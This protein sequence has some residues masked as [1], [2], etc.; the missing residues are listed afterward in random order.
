M[1]AKAGDDAISRAFVLDLD[2]DPLVGLIG[3]PRRFRISGVAA[4]PLAPGLAVPL[5]L[6]LENPHR[7]AIRVT[8]LSVGLDDSTSEPACSGS[9]NYT[10]A[11]YSGSYPLRLAPGKQ[12]LSE[13]TGSA[14]L[15]PRVGMRDLP[16]RQDECKGAR[17]SLLY[18]GTAVR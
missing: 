12:R 7:F 5:D 3:E 9:S 6:E 15:Y 11:Q 14:R 16:V 10:V 18:H 8:N 13:L 17:L 4:A 1:P 2:H